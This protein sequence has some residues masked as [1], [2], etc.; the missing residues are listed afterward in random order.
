[1]PPKAPLPLRPPRQDRSRRTLERILDVTE[2]LLEEQRFEAI[3][4]ARIVREAG[5]SVGAFYARFRDKDALLPALYQRY[6][7]WIRERAAGIEAA[8]PWEGMSFAGTVTWLVKE[9][10]QVFLARR[11]LMRAMVLHTRLRPDKVDDETKARRAQQMAFLK[12][13]LLD[14]R[15]SIHHPDPERAVDLAIYMAAA[16]CREWL[17][18]SDA[19]HASTT[20]GDTVEVEREIARQKLGYLVHQDSDSLLP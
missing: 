15:E 10:A 2:A 11:N 8:R 4:V 9:I 19:P 12:R 17:L 5:T 3:P 20:G 13:V 14:H 16:L 6:D 1:V 7:R 18:F